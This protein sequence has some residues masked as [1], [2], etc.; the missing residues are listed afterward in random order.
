MTKNICYQ[1]TCNVCKKRYIG[2]TGRYKR[3]RNWEHY[4]SVRDHTKSTAMGK[5]YLTDHPHMPRP[6]EPYTFKTRQRC[7]DFVDRQLWQSVLIKRECPDLNV[8]LSEIQNEGDWVKNTWKL[9]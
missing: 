5:H 4:K 9:M 3:H 2:E 8:Q 1:L 7:N 6:K